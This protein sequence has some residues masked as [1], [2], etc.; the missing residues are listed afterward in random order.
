[1]DHFKQEQGTGRVPWVKWSKSHRKAMERI[2]KGGNKILQDTGR[3]R[4]S[5]LPTQRRMSAEGILWFN[6][7]KTKK[8][9]P[10]AAAH[11]EGGEKLPARPFMWISDKTLDNIGAQTLKFLEEG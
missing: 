1:M 7:A 9:F 4:G 2:G 8:G 5:F 6:P 3:L 10:Y 11:Q